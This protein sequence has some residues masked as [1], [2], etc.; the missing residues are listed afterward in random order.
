MKEKTESSHPGDPLEDRESIPSSISHSLDSE[1]DPAYFP[2]SRSHSSPGFDS[3]L[4]CHVDMEA[5]Q[6]EIPV[7]DVF[8]TSGSSASMPHPSD[9]GGSEVAMRGAGEPSTSK[10]P[11]ECRPEFLELKNIWAFLWALIDFVKD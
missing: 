9:V 3:S 10:P 2:S 5:V 8:G 7:Q 6:G 11:I 1:F 4:S